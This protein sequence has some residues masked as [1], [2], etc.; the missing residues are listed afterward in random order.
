MKSIFFQFML[1][2]MMRMIGGKRY[3]GENIVGGEEGK[4][5][6]EI[7]D[8]TFRMSGA[9]NMEDFVPAMKWLGV[10]GLEK[11]MVVLKEKRDGFM[12]GVIEERRAM[13]DG[14]ELEGEGKK[15]MVEV[16]LSLQERLSQSIIRM[17]LSK[18]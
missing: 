2:I 4:R 15:T 16:L 7:V 12:Q 9:S 6:R 10:S 13:V 18:G 11:R 17:K 1:N 3:Y 14:S 8:E 5:F